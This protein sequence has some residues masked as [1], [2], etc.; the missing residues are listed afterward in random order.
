MLY[1]NEI[2]YIGDEVIVSM[3]DE[4]REWR[5]NVFPNGTK[6]LVIGFN[7][8]CYGRFNSFDIQP[9]VYLNKN[10]VQIKNQNGQIIVETAKHLRLADEDAY[11][12]RIKEFTHKSQLPDYLEYIRDLPPTPFWEGDKVRCSKHGNEYASEIFIINSIRY[13]DI[14]ELNLFGEP[15][16]PYSLYHREEDWTMGANENELELIERGNIWRYLNNEELKFDSLS[17][18]ANFFLNLGHVDE[19]KTIG[20]WTK[21]KVLEA[22]AKGK[23]DGFKVIRAIMDIP[24]YIIALKFHNEDLGKRVAKA[25]LEGF[26]ISN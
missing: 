21:T 17:E 13:L 5:T 26:N 9:G 7:E 12:A 1:P 4:D 25:T 18:E 23:A 16:N 8:V 2:F 22:I 15:S 6:A 20:E 19:V 11:K 24:P 10:L 3:T 14:N